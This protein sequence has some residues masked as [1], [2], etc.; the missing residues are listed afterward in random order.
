MICEVCRT[1]IPEGKAECPNCGYPVIVSLG[2]SPQAEEQKRAAAE[3]YRARLCQDIEVGFV[4]YSHKVTKQADGSEKLELDQA[5]RVRLGICGQMQTGQTVWC[6]EGFVRPLASYM[7][8]RIY[9]RR[10]NHS[11]GTRELKFPIRP[12]EGDLYIGV[13]KVSTGAVRICLT[14]KKDYREE[15]ADIALLNIN[16]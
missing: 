2:D 12:G 15:T 4:A 7:D 13:K 10:P 6:Q 9:I 14:D 1:Q 3:Q 8:C 16:G 11:E 5:D